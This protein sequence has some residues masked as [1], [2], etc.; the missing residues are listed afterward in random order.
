[1]YLKEVF[2]KGMNAEFGYGYYTESAGYST[3]RQSLLRGE[4]ESSSPWPVYKVGVHPPGM[5]PLAGQDLF[6]AQKGGRTL[7]VN[8]DGVPWMNYSKIG[9]G[10]V[11]LA[12][13][14]NASMKSMA[15]R[16]WPGHPSL[17]ESLARL[18]G[19]RPKFYG[20]GDAYSAGA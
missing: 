7:Y 5:S 3:R 17:F 14:S 20:D 6:A 13:D 4:G 1:M 2:G 12:S 18:G 8:G 9:R 10:A 11:V 15:K 16:P 19:H